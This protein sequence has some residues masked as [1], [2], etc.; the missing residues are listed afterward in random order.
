MNRI[1]LLTL[2]CLAAFLAGC[3]GNGAKKEPEPAAKQ[4]AVPPSYF[5]ADPA[6]AGVVSGTVKFSG[7]KPVRT[8]IDMDQEPACVT[9]HKGKATDDSVVVNS[10]GT[11]ANVFVYIKSG[12][13][14]KKFEPPAT[15]VVL[16]Q[17]GCWFRPRVIGIEVGQELSVTN[18]DPVTHNI[19]PL[20]QVNREWNHSQGQGDPPLERK[21][22]R[23]EIMIKVKCNVHNWMRAYIGVV[24]NPYYAVTG[25]NGSFHIANIPPGDYTLEAWQEKLGTQEQKITV[26]PSGKIV[27]A[28]GFQGE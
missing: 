10:N 5:K 21:F 13:E 25:A 16:D 20:A 27:T 24:E 8:V 17:N 23:P 2:C 6:T 19:H 15:P 22:V 18:S 14:G 4:A 12:L 28:F 9:A 1:R 3:S 11:L 7:K 26:T